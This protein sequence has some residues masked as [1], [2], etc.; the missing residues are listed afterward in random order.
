MTGTQY[1]MRAN[2][3]CKDAEAVSSILFAQLGWQGS[4]R[5]ASDKLDSAAVTHSSGSRTVQMTFA[6]GW[7][8]IISSTNCASGVSAVAT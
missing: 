8:S 7:I 1:T 6:S 4:V 2:R 5:I 3:D